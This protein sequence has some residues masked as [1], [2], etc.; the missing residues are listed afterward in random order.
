MGA[1]VFQGK[2]AM[3]HG[4]NLEGKIGPNLIDKIW[5][6]GGNNT[7]I[8]KTIREGVSV[9]GMPAWDGLLTNDEIFGI[10]ALIKSKGM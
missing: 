7:A 5:I 9:K 3:C 6:H 8:I 4:D 1:G 10:V 2:C